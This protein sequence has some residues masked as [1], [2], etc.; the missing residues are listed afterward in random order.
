MFNLNDHKLLF[1]RQFPHLRFSSLYYSNTSSRESETQS[2]LYMFSVYV[3]CKFECQAYI[4]V[5]NW[6]VLTY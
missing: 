2:S 3:L 4:Y 1:Q 6:E 5:I